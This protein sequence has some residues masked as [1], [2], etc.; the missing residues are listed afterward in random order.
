MI[1]VSSKEFV[2]YKDSDGMT[3]R[4]KPKSGTLEN[5]QL[6]LWEEGVSIKELYKRQDTF[7]EKILLSPIEEYKKA[8]YNTDEKAKIIKFWNDANKLTAEEKKS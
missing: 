6:N 1:P 3:W 2:E 5:E 4:F 8:D 7:I